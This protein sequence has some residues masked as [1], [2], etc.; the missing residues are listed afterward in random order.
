[1]SVLLIC[2][3]VYIYTYIYIYIYVCIYMCYCDHGARRGHFILRTAVIDSCELPC[4]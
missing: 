4:S 3:C 1:M 2:V